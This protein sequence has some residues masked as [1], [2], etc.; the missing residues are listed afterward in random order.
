MRPDSFPVEI[1]LPSISDEAVVE[2]HDF[3]YQFLDLFERRYGAQIHRFYDER[4]FDNFVHRDP[5]VVRPEDDPP[6]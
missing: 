3:L 4:Q 2:I 5:P 1:R 6:F